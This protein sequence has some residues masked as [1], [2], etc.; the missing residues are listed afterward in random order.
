[1]ATMA[2]NERLATLEEQ[3]RSLQSDVTEIKSDVKNLVTTQVTLATALA[4][5]EAS[6]ER[7][8]KNR[9]STGVWVR[10]FLPILVSVVAL[11]VTVVNALI[12]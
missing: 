5:K 12:R 9:A 7:E 2:E 8:R 10:T 11:I 4:V 1:M 3:F 6:E